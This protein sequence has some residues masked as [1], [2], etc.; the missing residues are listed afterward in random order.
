MILSKED[1][2]DLYQG[3]LSQKSQIL[4]V[5]VSN[6]IKLV[7]NKTWDYKADLKQITFKSLTKPS[8][9]YNGVQVE[10]I[11]LQPVANFTY[12]QITIKK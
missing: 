11:D 9:N 5:A 1:K 3:Y 7:F 2:H 10:T 6:N 8:I 12:Y 4:K